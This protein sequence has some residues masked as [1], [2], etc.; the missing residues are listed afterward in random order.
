MSDS[1]QRSSQKVFT[2]SQRH[3]VY[4]Q[5]NSEFK[6][7]FKKACSVIQSKE[8]KTQRRSSNIDEFSY[9]ENYQNKFVPSIESEKDD[10]NENVKNALQKLKRWRVKEDNVSLIHHSSNKEVIVSVFC[11]I[12]VR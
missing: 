10:I 9:N 7:S 3:A 4:M 5:K 2:V 12:E 6:K 8:L 11:E 1:Q